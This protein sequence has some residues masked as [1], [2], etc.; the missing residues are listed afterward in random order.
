MGTMATNEV[1]PPQKPI[2][3]ELLMLLLSPGNSPAPK[4]EE[5][6]RICETGD[7]TV[8]QTSSAN[9]SSSN[10]INNSL[11]KPSGQASL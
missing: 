6:K 9:A 11:A 2:P 1:V 7:Q 10:S 4:V 3:F 5:I 8:S